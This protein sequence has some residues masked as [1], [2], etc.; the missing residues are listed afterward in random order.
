VGIRCADHVTPHYPQKLALTSLTGDGRSVGI[1]RVRTKATV[2]VCFVTSPQT[3]GIHTAHTFIIIIRCIRNTTDNF[4]RNLLLESKVVVCSFLFR[5]SQSST[6]E[7]AGD[8]LHLGFLR[9]SSVH[10][11]IAVRAL[12]YLKTCKELEG[13][14]GQRAA[15]HSPPYTAAVME[16]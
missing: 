5:S 11:Y 14:S 12:Y 7:Y 6:D 3:T 2:F 16:E 9:F 4:R 8:R 13:L 1:V 10:P 15:D